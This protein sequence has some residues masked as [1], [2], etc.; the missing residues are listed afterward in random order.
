MVLKLD[1]PFLQTVLKCK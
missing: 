1:N